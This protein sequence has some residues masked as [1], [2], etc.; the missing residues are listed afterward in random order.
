MEL[1]CKECGQKFN[2]EKEAIRHS[3]ENEGHVE[4]RFKTIGV[5]TEVT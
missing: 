3:A 1:T 5:I 4:F 2:S